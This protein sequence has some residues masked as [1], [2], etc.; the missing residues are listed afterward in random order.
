MGNHCIWEVYFQIR[1]KI[2]FHQRLLLNGALSISSQGAIILASTLLAFFSF[3]PGHGLLTI[4]PS[5]SSPLPRDRHLPSPCCTCSSITKTFWPITHRKPQCVNLSAPR[6]SGTHL[7]HCFRRRCFLFAS[8]SSLLKLTELITCA[9]HLSTCNKMNFNSLIYLL[10][11]QASEI[12]ST[13]L[14]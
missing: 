13:L 8:N 11:L 10:F 7:P 9:E 4:S 6:D 14:L 1:T 12:K 5:P 2:H 3:S